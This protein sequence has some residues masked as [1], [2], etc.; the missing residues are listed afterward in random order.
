MTKRDIKQAA[1]RIA[2]AWI[3]SDH[4]S[5]ELPWGSSMLPE[6]EPSSSK[7]IELEEAIRSQPSGHAEAVLRVLN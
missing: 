5:A 4:S 6:A 3:E 7:F 1:R 2:G